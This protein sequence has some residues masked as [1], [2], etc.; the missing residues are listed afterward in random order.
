MV[1]RC[2]WCGGYILPGEPITLYT[3]CS[4]DFKI[5]DYA[6]VYK[7]DPKQLVGCLRWNC[8]ESGADRTGFWIIPG[9][10]LRC[11]S[12]IEEL[13]SDSKHDAVIINDL[14]DINQAKIISD[15]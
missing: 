3:P 5:P 4:E 6:V 7:E 12:P 10:V 1:I 2:A 13:M 9:K 14:G 8:A 11:L 15:N